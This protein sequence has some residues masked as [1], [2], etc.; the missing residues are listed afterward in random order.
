MLGLVLLLFIFGSALAIAVAYAIWQRCDQSLWT[1]PI[2]YSS[3]SIDREEHVLELDATLRAV[4]FPGNCSVE[5]ECTV[6]VLS[7]AA[8][9]VQ[10]S[11]MIGYPHIGFIFFDHVNN[12]EAGERLTEWACALAADLPNAK[13]LATDLFV[14]MVMNWIDKGN[15][16][17]WKGRVALVDPED[18]FDA[19]AR[20]HPVLE[21]IWEMWRQVCGGEAP[22]NSPQF[23]FTQARLL[24]PGTAHRYVQIDPAYLLEDLFPELQVQQ[25]L[26][27]SPADES[28][29]EEAPSL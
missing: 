25:D 7:R 5:Q 26:C 4:F 2:T 29:A 15:E 24:F 8:K 13:L 23:L 10:R 22:F 20:L 11:L 18:R 3:P 6:I 21:F 17:E 9:G 28:L 1:T 12:Y 16:E 14:P 19:A 27:E